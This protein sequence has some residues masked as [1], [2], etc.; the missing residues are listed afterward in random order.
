MD[1]YVIVW[2]LETVPDLAV[3]ARHPWAS[4]DRNCLGKGGAR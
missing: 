3:V 2:D 4:S 1:D